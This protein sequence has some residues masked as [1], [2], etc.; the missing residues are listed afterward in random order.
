MV[1]LCSLTAGIV[2]GEQKDE[3]TRV[4]APPRRPPSNK[5]WTQ[6]GFFSCVGY[7]WQKVDHHWLPHLYAHFN[8]PTCLKKAT[9]EC[10][11][12]K[13][14]RCPSHIHMDLEGYY[15]RLCNTCYST[16]NF[17]DYTMRI[18]R[19]ESQLLAY[20]ATEMQEHLSKYYYPRTRLRKE[21]HMLLS[22]TSMIFF[23]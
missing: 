11:R 3:A 5:E 16:S 13:V 9:A 18:A 23:Q 2:A 15:K 17:S 14:L 19:V 20:T 8:G 10:D 6:I 7:E 4:R 22:V 12:C 1:C 21:I